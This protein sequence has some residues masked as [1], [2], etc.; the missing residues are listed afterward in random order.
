MIVGV[1]F[2]LTLKII[3]IYFIFSCPKQKGR[4]IPKGCNYFAV[5]AM[6]GNGR[7]LQFLK[8][9]KITNIFLLL[10][11]ILLYTSFS[12]VRHAR[13]PGY[14]IMSSYVLYLLLVVKSYQMLGTAAI[15]MKCL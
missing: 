2:F 10:Y 1:S 13:S 6:G 11:M 12:Q 15:I 4:H 8:K 3:D 14:R 9:K 5:L 7:G